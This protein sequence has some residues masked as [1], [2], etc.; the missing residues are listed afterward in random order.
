VRR[1]E[2]Y[3]IEENDLAVTYGGAL[4]VHQ[5]RV[6]RQ[7]RRWGPGVG[8]ARAGALLLDGRP[9]KR[10]LQD[11]RDEAAPA[12]VGAA[13]GG[14]PGGCAGPPA[15]PTAPPGGPRPAENPAGG[16]LEPAPATVWGGAGG[17]TSQQPWVRRDVLSVSSLTTK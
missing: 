3:L 1:R 14:R 17:V 6:R 13:R 11:R 9:A 15:A 2:R 7:A 12:E 5:G 16:A 8:R 10:S 4:L